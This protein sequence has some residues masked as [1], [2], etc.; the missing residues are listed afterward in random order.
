MIGKYKRLRASEEDCAEQMTEVH[1]ILT[2]DCRE[3]ALNDDKWLLDREKRRRAIRCFSVRATVG[4]W[5]RA[6][7]CGFRRQANV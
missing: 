4:A 3:N 1:V 7:I 6:R 2:F 5:I